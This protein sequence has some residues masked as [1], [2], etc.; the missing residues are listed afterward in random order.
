MEI[1]DEYTGQSFQVPPEEEGLVGMMLQQGRTTPEI[2]AVLTQP[3]VDE[4]EQEEKVYAYFPAT[5]GTV[6]PVE[7]IPE[8]QPVRNDHDSALD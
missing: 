5:D 1:Y 4:P 3:R 2:V 7:E 8:L 6:I